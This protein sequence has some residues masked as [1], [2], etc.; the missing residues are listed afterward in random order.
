MFH[1]NLASLGLHKDELVTSLSLLSFEFD[2]IAVSE[3]KIKAG[4]EPIYDLS[5]AG[6]L[7]YQTPSES[8]KGG[9][10]IY[11]KENVITKR[12]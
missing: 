12:R 4:T 5:L 6:Y 7:H 11:T 10:I 1:L 3:T 9:V 8:D 2:M